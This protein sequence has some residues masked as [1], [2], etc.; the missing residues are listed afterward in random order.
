MLKRISAI[1]TLFEHCKCE[2]VTGKAV[3]LGYERDGC[4][5]I[6]RECT[7]YIFRELG[8]IRDLK[9]RLVFCKPLYSAANNTL[10]DAT[11]GKGTG[12]K[13]KIADISLWEP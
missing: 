2:G 5:K 4:R 12:N 13:E 1:R 6:S 8:Q 9:K 10:Y 11:N 7:A 3:S